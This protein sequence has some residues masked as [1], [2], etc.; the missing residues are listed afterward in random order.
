MILKAVDYILKWIENNKK[1]EFLNK[2]YGLIDGKVGDPDD[3]YHSFMLNGYAYLGLQRVSEMSEKIEESC[4][5]KIK[6]SAMELKNNIRQSFFSAMARCP[7]MPAGDGT[8]VLAAPPWPEHDGLVI[9]YVDGGKWFTHGSFLCRDSLV[10]PLYLIFQVI[11]EPDEIA[12][13]NWDAGEYCPEKESIILK[14]FTNS[15]NVTL[16]F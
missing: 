3:F 12:A 16:T 10:G 6:Q 1:E 14:K 8:W 2:G 15:I 9:H 7:V 4:A 13:R 5:G 11:I